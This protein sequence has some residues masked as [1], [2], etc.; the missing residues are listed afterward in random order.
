MEKFATHQKQLEQLQKLCIDYQTRLFKE[1]NSIEPPYLSSKDQPFDLK[2]LNKPDSLPMSLDY[3]WSSPE[4]DNEDIK[5]IAAKYNRVQE[6]RS[7]LETDTGTAYEK[8]QIFK[9]AL[10]DTDTQ[11]LINKHRDGGFTLFLKNAFFILTT[12]LAGMGLILAYT[13]KNSLAF[14]KSH[15]Q[16]LTETLRDTLDAEN[17]E[18]TPKMKNHTLGIAIS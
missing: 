10:N 8:M 18:S 2:N 1:W 13:S 6:L 11:T 9:A 12:P 7:L 14:W 15:G 5:A 17:D 4:S 16:I 3:L